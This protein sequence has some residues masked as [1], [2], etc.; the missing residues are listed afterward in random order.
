MAALLGAWWLARDRRWPGVAVLAASLAV[1]VPV[2]YSS[3]ATVAVALAVAGV[4][5]L[6]VSRSSRHVG[7]YLLIGVNLAAVV[8]A[9]I[10]AHALKWPGVNET[11]Q[12]TFTNHFTQPDVAD[13]WSRLLRLD[14][15]FWHQWLQ[16]QFRAPWLLLLVAVGVWGAF[17]AGPV[18]GTLVT[19]VAATGPLT[20]FAHPVLREHERLMEALW[21]APVLGVPLL[22]MWRFDRT[23][24]ASTGEEAP[25][26]SSSQRR[27]A[28]F[29][30]PEA[31]L[32][33]PGGGRS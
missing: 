16:T 3:M 25:L 29:P 1:L 26:V 24:Q 23:D 31:L 30:G 20:V 22:L 10:V 15:H 21:I 28:R 4:V 27:D 12:D 18:F 7:T 11:L 5:A 33:A 2:R 17:R 13:P 19:A 8:A 9:G 32:R 6:A 14:V